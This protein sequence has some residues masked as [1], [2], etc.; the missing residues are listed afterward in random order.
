[1]DILNPLPQVNYLLLKSSGLWL[2]VWAIRSKWDIDYKLSAL[3]KSVRW[4]VVFICF[5]LTSVPGAS[6]GWFR[7]VAYLTGTS[8]LCWPNLAYHLAKAFEEWPTTEARVNSVQQQSES[9]VTVA[10]DFEVGGERYGGDDSVAAV[11]NATIREA[12]SEGGRILIR[13]DPL[14]PGRASRIQRAVLSPDLGAAQATRRQADVKIASI[15]K[16][17]NPF[18]VELAKCSPIVLPEVMEPHCCCS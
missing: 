8:F 13:Y 3:G 9:L 11:G 6:L 5:A 14:N 16:L 4:A 2:S 15:L 10:Y 1:M 7:I 12:F 17:N 18:R